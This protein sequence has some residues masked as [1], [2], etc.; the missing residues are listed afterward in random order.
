[1]RS[2]ARARFRPRKAPSQER[3]IATVDAILG[4]TARIL[5]SRGY[6]EL[7]TN[8]VAKR[9]GVS[10]GT[11]YEW[12]PGKEALVAGLVDRHLARVEARLEERA[13]ALAGAAFSMGP[14]AIGSALAEAMV[15]LHEDD[16]RLHRAL[17]EEV[18]LPAE[19]RARIR[20]LEEQM[21]ERLAI[22]FAAHPQIATREPLLTARMVVVLLEAATHRWATD[23]S[24]EPIARDVL[25][26][27]LANMIGAYLVA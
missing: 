21:V 14:T 2:A 7:T 5:V 3:A 17:T 20:A 27:E 11:L 24:G 1:M 26:R 8:H 4:A 22:L 25:V 23:R 6:A 15:E 18:P 16:P 12:F 9:A 13:L 19:T 10:V